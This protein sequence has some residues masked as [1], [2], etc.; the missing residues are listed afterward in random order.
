MDCQWYQSTITLMNFIPKLVG[1][2]KR[3]VGHIVVTSS[4]L[5]RALSA[6]SDAMVAAMLPGDIVID[7]VT[8]RYLL[9]R[10]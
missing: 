9:P 2:T 8:V 3:G 6:R 4:D 10:P 5:H 1:A 7:K